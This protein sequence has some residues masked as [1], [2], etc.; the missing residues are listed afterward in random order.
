MTRLRRAVAAVRQLHDRTPLRVRLVAILLVLVTVALA[1]AGFGAVATLRGYLVGRVDA[2]LLTATRGF[3]EHGIQPGP[4]SEGDTGEPGGLPSSFVVQLTD[5]R[6]DPV[7]GP[8]NNLLDTRQA[9]PRLPTLTV[10][11]VS[12]RN[13]EPFTVSATQGSGQWRVV[14]VALADGSGSMFVAQSLADVQSTVA[15]LVLVELVIG[16]AVV[17]LLAG[18]AYLVVRASLRPLVEVENTAAAIAAGDLSRRIP[19][20]DPRTEVGR[21]SAAL[22]GMLHQIEGAFRVRQASESAARRS[23]ERMRR[24]VADASHE[25]RTPLTSIRGF[26]EL[27]R[28]GA[29]A[30]PAAIARVLRRIEDEAARMG[31]LVDDLLLLARLDEQRPL[32]RAPVDLLTV[33]TDAVE[34]ARLVDPDRPVTLEVAT[35]AGAPVVVGDE[36]RLHQVLGNLVTNALRHT[37]AGTPVGVRIATQPGSGHGPALAVIEVRDAGPGLAPQDAERIF[38]RFY[39]ADATRSR[40]GGGSG[41]G[42]AIVAALVA[43]HGGQVHLDTA[44]GRGATFRVE[45]PLAV[46]AVAGSTVGAAQVAAAH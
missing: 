20:R 2:Q 17:A 40:D 8:Y 10:A 15:R 41:L 36:A 38:E 25:L 29:A 19:D 5:A 43:G 32:E 42:L 21:L 13:A 22:N 23:E 39:R 27:Y 31:V 44:P 30:D 24:F 12:A 3:V 6:G 14:A 11:Q 9:P 1:A 46:D 34:A 26:A 16:L 18:I 7:G 4:R 37:P 45:L 28:Q 35:D 33:A